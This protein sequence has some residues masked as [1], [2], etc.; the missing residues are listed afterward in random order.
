MR[1][2]IATYPNNSKGSPTVRTKLLQLDPKG[3]TCTA[4]EYGDGSKAIAV[5]CIMPIDEMRQG[6]KE[7]RRAGVHIA[8]V[9]ISD[10]TQDWEKLCDHAE[11]QLAAPDVFQA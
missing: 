9:G 7:A 6:M 3:G 8:T 11:K 4:I 2:L 1:R 5:T 10:P